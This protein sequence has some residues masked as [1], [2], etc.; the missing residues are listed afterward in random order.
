M[1]P[2]T[3]AVKLPLVAQD[4][5]INDHLSR[6]DRR[7]VGANAQWCGLGW[8]ELTD[9]YKQSDSGAEIER[10]ERAEIWVPSYIVIA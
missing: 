4:T 6:P 1:P 8:P 7:S 10:A 5:W 3:I 2:D 9:L